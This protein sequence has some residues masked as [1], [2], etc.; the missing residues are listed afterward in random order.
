MN[1]L[2]ILYTPIDVPGAPKVDLEAL[3]DWMAETE[4]I[5]YESNYTTN[6]TDGKNKITAFGK[7]YPWNIV[8]PRFNKVWK[9]NFDVLFPELANFFLTAF[10]VDPNQIW[11]V[12]MLPTKSDFEGLGFW[13]ADA[14]YGLRCYIENQETEDFLR[15]RPSIIPYEQKTMKELDIY[16]DV[17]K[18]AQKKEYSAKLL[19]SN[20]VFYLN[21]IR[22]V[23]AVN[24]NKP[25]ALRIA[26]IIH[27]TV[28]DGKAN[29]K[30]QELIVR[31]AEKF[32]DYSI[33]WT[34]PDQST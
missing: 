26:C 9:H 29:E 4:K 22:A 18:L 30:L 19:S 10:P 21:N 31:S 25:G 23:H 15:I 5:S 14:E 16:A 32:S 12:V 33:L 3:L 28:N 27:V 7:V 13:H 2:D 24:V 20:Q 11:S 1:P 6:R 17:D 34:P 8:Y